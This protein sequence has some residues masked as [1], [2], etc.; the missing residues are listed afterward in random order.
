[1]DNVPPAAS[2][3]DKEL[4]S[5]FDQFDARQVLHVTFG[6]VL[7]DYG[8]RLKAVLKANLGLYDQYLQIHFKRHLKPFL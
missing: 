4:L 6:S 8:A 3:T 2:L 7:D 5:L 1:M